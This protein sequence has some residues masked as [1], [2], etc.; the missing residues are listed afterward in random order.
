[1][2]FPKDSDGDAL[3]LVVDAGADLTRTMII[4]FTV[5]AP[6]ERAARSIADVVEAQGFD[7]SIS[8]EGKD[9]GW[10][11]YCSVSM[12]A[13]YEGVI[14]ARARLNELSKPYGGH[15]D[16]WATF[17]NRESDED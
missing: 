12:L 16:R 9:G 15:C 2:D 6:D 17:G 5:S 4:D 11:V 14:E 3:R 13:T 8:D 7:P 1:M 10:S